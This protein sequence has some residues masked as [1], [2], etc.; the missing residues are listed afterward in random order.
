[1]GR[2]NKLLARHKG[3]YQVIGKRQSIYIIEDLVKSKQ[4][5]LAFSPTQ[6]RSA[7]RAR[8][9]SRRDLSTSWQPSS[10]IHHGVPSPMAR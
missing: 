1:M 3:P 6:C 9:R 8:I 10:K 5:R 4:M 2:S 7:E